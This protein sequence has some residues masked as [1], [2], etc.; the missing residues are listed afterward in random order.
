MQVVFS[1]KNARVFCPENASAPH[2]IINS[3][4]CRSGLVWLPQACHKFLSIAQLFRK[5]TASQKYVSYKLRVTEIQS[6]C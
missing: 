6:N 4:N 3:V 2:D 5:K 1:Q